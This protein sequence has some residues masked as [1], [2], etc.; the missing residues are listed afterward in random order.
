MQ[1]IIFT[2]RQYIVILYLLQDLYQTL[3]EV[4]SEVESVIATGRKIVKE[5]QSSDPDG[6]TLQLD[7]LKALYNKVGV[8]YILYVEPLT[9]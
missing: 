7:Q 5:G 4:K 2:I 9:E 3:S 8:P 1:S 6:L